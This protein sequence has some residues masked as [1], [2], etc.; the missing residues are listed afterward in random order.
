M[1]LASVQILLLPVVFLLIASL[2]ID[3]VRIP[4][5][6]LLCSVIFVLLCFLRIHWASTVRGNEYLVARLQD[7]KYDAQTHVLTTRLNE[8]LLPISGV[9]AGTLYKEFKRKDEVR[10]Y[11]ESHKETRAIIWGSKKWLNISFQKDADFVLSPANSS[12]FFL[13]FYGLKLLSSVP[14]QGISYEPFEGVRQFLGHTLPSYVSLVDHS[15]DAKSTKAIFRHRHLMYA[16]GIVD[17]WRSLGH[18]AL[19]NCLSANY[20]F[21]E[22]LQL[23]EYDGELFKML[24][25]RYAR[26]ASYVK[27]REN[28]ELY[29]AIYNNLGVASFIR[30]RIIG[31]KNMR[32]MS[33]KYLKKA[34]AIDRKKASRKHIPVLGEMNSVAAVARQN[35]DFV[36]QY[37][38]NKGKRSGD[39]SKEMS[40]KEKRQHLGKKSKKGG[41]G[42]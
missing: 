9:E 25:K 19:P 15:R 42:R 16:A 23:P 3:G 14:H 10:D 39:V 13:R 12:S 2:S 24:R 22:A 17:F 30:S 4:R 11:L 40:A 20:L 34:A 33:V 7:D 28:P 36:R 21:V 5:A 18:R 29:G 38:L 35:L 6:V 8:I 1:D 37:R 26:A 41:K 27:F 32:K 31:N